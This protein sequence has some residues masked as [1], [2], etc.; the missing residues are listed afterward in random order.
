M[1]SRKFASGAILLAATAGIA[2]IVRTRPDPAVPEGKSGRLQATT[3]PSHASPAGPVQ[4]RPPGLSSADPRRREFLERVGRRDLKAAA[5]IG[6]KMVAE[7]LPE[8]QRRIRSFVAAVLSEAAAKAFEDRHAPAAELFSAEEVRKRVENA[9]GDPKQRESV[10]ADLLRTRI[11]DETYPDVL[12]LL[13]QELQGPSPDPRAVALLNCFAGSTG[14]EDLL[15][16]ASGPGPREIRL[17]ALRQ[18][19][20]R[21]RSDDDVGR[22]QKLCTVEQDPELRASM[23]LLVGSVKGAE[24]EP[25]FL[26][27][28]AD[29]SPQVRSAAISGLDPTRDS[30]VQALSALLNSEPESQVRASALRQLNGHLENPPLLQR[31]LA[32]TASDPSEDV[33]LMG[34]LCL[35]RF[36]KNDAAILG[37]L[38]RLAA[39]DSA[40]EVRDMARTVRVRLDPSR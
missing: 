10:Y 16:L 6:E 8:D 37:T 27:S 2:F 33:R 12:R 39:S 14:K 38:D 22:I 34:I 21:P 17:E 20:G 40:E 7:A 23:V 31:V 36:G 30:A 5:E 4:G 11:P 35:G 32:L 9:L 3:S 15:T 19:N 28:L 18:L 1:N 29:A 13:R 25:L 24:T 26:A